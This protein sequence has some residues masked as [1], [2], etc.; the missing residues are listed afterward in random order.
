MGGWPKR[1]LV[2]D[3]E[4]VNA[5]LGR[6]EVKKEGVNYCGGWDDHAGMG[7]SV[8]GAWDSGE[9][10]YR[11]FC[12]DNCDEFGDLAAQCDLLV[13]HNSIGFDNK[14]LAAAGLE[15]DPAKCY[16][17]MLACAAGGSRR[18]MGLGDLCAANFDVPKSGS[19]A[20]A[21][22]A[23]QAGR[24]G[25]VIDYCL[26]D[27]RMTKLLFERIVAKGSVIHPQTGRETP[28]ERPW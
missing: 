11:V 5:I 8:I 23:W 14:V 19:G 7:V 1:V 9:D 10:R 15:L 24:V 21:P 3:L 22:P 2:Y 6:G 25:W 18:G 13:G 17:T 12:A 28:V 27:V 20:D 16:D 4:I 26:H